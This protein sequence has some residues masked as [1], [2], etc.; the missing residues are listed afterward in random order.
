MCVCVR[1]G[2]ERERE[3]WGVRGEEG[4]ECAEGRGERVGEIA[5]APA[6]RDWTEVA[7]RALL[8]PDSTSAIS[9]PTVTS[10]PFA[11]YLLNNMEG[12]CEQ[13][14]NVTV[15][16]DD[17]STDGSSIGST[18]VEEET[19][20]KVLTPSGVELF[21]RFSFL[22][23]SSGSAESTEPNQP[24]GTVIFGVGGVGLVVVAVVAV[25]R[26]RGRY[27]SVPDG[28]EFEF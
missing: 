18:A 13:Y 19:A 20:V 21:E 9:P 26:R 2:R 27:S 10:G 16:A 23:G 5:R 12:L 8:S 22:L 6:A 7:Q 24:T 25:T 1:E 3:R 17:T 15:T 28:G 14:D 4:K 11:M